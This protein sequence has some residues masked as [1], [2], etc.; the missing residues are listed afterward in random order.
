MIVN[1]SALHLNFSEAIKTEDLHNLSNFKTET[2]I[3]KS[4]DV[5]DGRNIRV[6]FSGILPCK[7][8]VSM[9]VS[10][11]HDMAGNQIKDTTFS[12]SY[13]PGEIFDIIIT[14]IMADPDPPVLLQNTEYLELYNKSG[15]TLNLENWTL[16]VGNTIKKFPAFEMLPESFLIVCAGGTCSQFPNK[17][18]LDILS[19]SELNNSGEYTAIRNAKTN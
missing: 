3:I 11:L 5:A 7:D 19:S 17:P 10:G 16:Q 15:I 9:H 14:E 2:V 6:L 1:D 12:V 8:P 18:C 13:C 4:I